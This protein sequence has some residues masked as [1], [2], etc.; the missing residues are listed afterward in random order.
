MVRGM[1]PLSA[2]WSLTFVGCGAHSFVLDC[3]MTAG[4]PVPRIEPGPLL[5]WRVVKNGFNLAS[6]I[7]PIPVGPP[8]MGGRQQDSATPPQGGQSAKIFLCR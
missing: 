1:G 2:V 8:T 3:N 5:L 6:A 4:P 7:L